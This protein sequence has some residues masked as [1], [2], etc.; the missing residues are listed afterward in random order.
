MS[1][2]AA[3]AIPASLLKSGQLS[4][5][6]SL[7]LLA[8]ITVSYLASSSAPTPLYP[9]YQ[10]EWGFSPI[11][12]AF[13]FGVY[14]VAVLAAL[15]VTGRLSDYVGRRPVLIVATAIQAATMLLFAFA[16]GLSTLIAARVIQG[17]STGAAIAAVGAGM[18]DIDKIRGAVANS[19]APASGTALGGVLAGLMVHYLPAPTHL[20]YLVL[21]AIFVAQVIGVVLMSETM[22]PRAGA[23]A[24]LWPQFSLPPATRQPILVAAPVLIAVWALAGFY[25]SLAPS[26]VRTSF[27]LDSSLL[28]GIA[29]FV[30][31]GSGGISV[32]LTQ[33]LEPRTLMIYGATVL[34]AG[35]AL[36]VSSLSYHSA[37]AFF[38]GTALAGSGFGTGFQGAIKTVVPLAAP[39]ERGGVLSVIFVVSYLAMGLPAVIAGYFIARQGDLFLTAR[40]FGAVVMVL[41]AL[42]L[43]GMMR[44]TS[45]QLIGKAH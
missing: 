15:L 28:G 30:L 10:A 16:D 35:V 29:L 34:F 18:M 2:A 45:S 44:R 17:L 14:A 20:V 22:P 8:S 3:S 31:A 11:A 21:A 13:V 9:I 33:R 27:G 25:G 32:L 41:A 1:E 39:Q 37:T 42:A 40:E 7:C 5:T 6:C 24:S 26:L 36:A 43:I 19:V 12:I 38:L 4:Q 23:M